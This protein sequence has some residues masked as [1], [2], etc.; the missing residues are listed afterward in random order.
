VVFSEKKFAELMRQDGVATPDRFL[1]RSLGAHPS[2]AQ[3][4][5]AKYPNPLGLACRGH[6]Q[7][8]S[9]WAF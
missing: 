9:F 5:F 6:F 8:R 3:L 2:A 1:D 7:G 4:F